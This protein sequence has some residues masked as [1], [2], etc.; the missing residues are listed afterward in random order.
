MI[1]V[2]Y[3]RNCMTVRLQWRP[4][5]RLF[6][7]EW[8]VFQQ[9]ATSI[10]QSTGARASRLFADVSTSTKQAV[11]A[12]VSARELCAA[13]RASR[14]SSST[15]LADCAGVPMAA[16]AVTAA[17]AAAEAALA[18][19]VAALAPLLACARPNTA[20]DVT[21]LM[22]LYCCMLRY[23]CSLAACCC[24]M[25]V[26]VRH[27]QEASALCEGTACRVCC[28][29]DQNLP[30]LQQR[31]AMRRVEEWQ[32]WLLD[33]EE[34]FHQLIRRCSCSSIHRQMRCNHA[35]GSNDCRCRMPT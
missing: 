5:P 17:V 21:A 15:T 7:C 20:T 34:L 23:S 3:A 6:S 2:A 28:K 19:A 11:G 8:A 32:K 27:A 22:A 9:Q 33:A 12:I 14:C 4:A 30:H 31:A 25:Y 1:S 10:R 29:R 18:A 16:V 24:Q 26:H 13:C 35:H